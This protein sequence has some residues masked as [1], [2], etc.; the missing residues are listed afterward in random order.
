MIVF[1]RIQ[2]RYISTASVIDKISPITRLFGTFY[3]DFCHREEREQRA[4]GSSL[5]THVKF[6]FDRYPFQR[7]I[8]LCMFGSPCFVRP[9]D[10]MSPIVATGKHFRQSTKT[11]SAINL[12]ALG[13]RSWI[14]I[15]TFA[16][17]GMNDWC[18]SGTSVLW[19]EEILQS[20]HKAFNRTL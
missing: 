6:A 18:D 17:N 10:F 11:L 15:M 2:C 14:E 1:N 9:P 4:I 19:R 7:R 20:L 13:E 5:R 3:T 8:Q 12:S 16:T